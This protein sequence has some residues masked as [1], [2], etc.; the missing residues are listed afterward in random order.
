ML[1]WMFACAPPPSWTE[2]GALAGHR[3]WLD[4]NHDGRVDAG[5][6]EGHLWN[7]PPM[8]SADLDGD[9]DLSAAELSALVVAQSPTHFDGAVES[10]PVARAGAG[11]R[12]P[13]GEAKQLWEVL[14][15]MDDAE[16]SVGEPGLDPA[17]VAAAVESGSF[18]SAP[19]RAA[20]AALRPAWS[21]HGWTW[22]EGIP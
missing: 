11:V 15:W 13:E 10:G 4:T 20:F 19:S 5:E 21:A 9:G 2:A 16:R 8:G 7:G 3:A 18:T 12:T 17:Q 1:V 6:Y 14:V 22:P